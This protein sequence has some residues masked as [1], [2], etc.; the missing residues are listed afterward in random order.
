[1]TT[2]HLYTLVKTNMTVIFLA[3]LTSSIIIF[4][5]IA[6]YLTEHEHHGAN[7][8]NLGDALWW[9]V[10]TIAT[11]G[12]GDYYPVTAAG[13]L[14]AIFMMLSGI[15]IFVLLVNTLAQRRLQRRESRLKSKTKLQSRI[16]DQETTKAIKNKTEE[17][18]NLTEED[19]D[20]LI[21]L[22]KSLRR[23]LFEDS[24]TLFNCSRCGEPYH[25]KSKFCSSCGLDLSSVQSHTP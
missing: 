25:N 17:I 22:M 7:I 20:T 10:V 19:F 3:V 13:R 16:L 9:A 2:N 8:T 6:V 15:G 1:M 14:I 5:G 18:E 12:Y 11:V 4:G 23:T 24:K 21:M